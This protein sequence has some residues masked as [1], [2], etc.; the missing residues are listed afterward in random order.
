VSGR[1]SEQL[2]APGDGAADACACAGGGCAGRCLAQRASCVRFSAS[3]Q[4][5]SSSRRLNPLRVLRTSGPASVAGASV[6]NKT[7][8]TLGLLGMH[9][10]R[11][12]PRLCR[13]S[14]S[15]TNRQ[16]RMCTCVGAI[17][18][19]SGSCGLAW[20]IHVSAPGAGILEQASSR[21]R[22]RLLPP[23]LLGPRSAARPA[24]WVIG[25]FS[26]D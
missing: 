15:P 19:T 7:L 16:A 25:A 18:A 22:A 14:S 11:Q 2:L 13:C 21:R 4:L 12:R 1:R 24:P 5:A 20:A 3:D 6:D 10:A 23:G 26:R 9:V 17:A 8:A